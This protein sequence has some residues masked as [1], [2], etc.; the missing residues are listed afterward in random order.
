MFYSQIYNTLIDSRF[1]ALLS[2]EKKDKKNS[3][4]LLKADGKKM[5][6]YTMT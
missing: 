2:L 4:L 5:Y 3:F 6:K 1:H